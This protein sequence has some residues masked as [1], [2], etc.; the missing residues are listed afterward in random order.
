MRSG[1]RIFVVC[2][3]LWNIGALGLF[4]PGI[5]I[6][7]GGTLT[8]ADI[9]WSSFF[10]ALTISIIGLVGLYTHL[11]NPH[12]QL[13]W[14][15]R[16]LRALKHITDGGTM[17]GSICIIVSLGMGI[18]RFVS[19]V[20]VPYGFIGWMLASGPLL[21]LPSYLLEIWRLDN[22]GQL[23]GWYKSQPKR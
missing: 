6:A 1:M 7:G 15:E 11:K 23:L 9:S 4:L 16:E 20:Q 12:E 22:L 18:L 13:S 14:N 3:G 8:T 21:L 5:I 19:V 10:G 17:L 2:I